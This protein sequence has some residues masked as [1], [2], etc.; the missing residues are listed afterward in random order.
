MNSRYILLCI[1]V[2]SAFPHQYIRANMPVILINEIGWMG[3][4]NSANDEWVELKNTTLESVDL[5]GWIL[6]SPEGK[7]NIPLT[8]IVL[9]NSFYLLER[10]DDA[11]VPNITAD[12]IYKGALNNN[13]ANLELYN[14][15]NILI[16][17][18]KYSSGWPAGNNETKRT[19]ERIGL[20]V[21]QTSKDSNGTPRAENSTGLVKP[22]IKDEPDKNSLTESKKI[23]NKNSVVA[24]VAAIHAGNTDNSFLIL[25][26]SSILVLLSGG[27]IL[28]LKINQKLKFK[29][30]N[31][32]I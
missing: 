27:V 32:D 17:S 7:L 5:S 29:S 12:F 13:G 28:Y 22:K 14:S 23:D 19:A 10:T 9:A 24:G 20:T 2:F 31:F 3:H 16:D 11:S 6:K 15:S 21:W 30:K 8:G 25:L 26:I 18:A 4:S 1:L